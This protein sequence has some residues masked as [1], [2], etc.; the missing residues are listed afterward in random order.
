MINDKYIK[1]VYQSEPIGKDKI[2]L[3]LTTFDV[4]AYER[5]K[6]IK[7][8]PKKTEQI[9]LDIPKSPDFDYISYLEEKLNAYVKQ[10]YGFYVEQ[11][12][13]SKYLQENVID[14][15]EVGFKK[16]I[17]GNVVNADNVECDIIEGNVINCDSVKCNEVKGKMINCN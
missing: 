9:A 14:L 8:I 7:E 16:V 6:N 12:K 1:I 13:A 5:D 11:I 17:K 4:E 15:H 3:Y 10:Y 2:I